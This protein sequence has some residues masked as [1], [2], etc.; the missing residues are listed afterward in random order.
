MASR[1]APDLLSQAMA[2]HQHG[3]LAEAEPLYRRLVAEQP[4][5]ARGHAMLGYLLLQT[6]RDTEALLVLD[7][8]VALDQKLAEAHAWRG[9]VLQRAGRLD[10]AVV[11]YTA[12]VQAD[13]R[14]MGA[15]N[16]LGN[17]LLL[18]RRT[19][20]A[21]PHLQRAIDLGHV[22]PEPHV[23]LGR[24]F[25]RLG[26]TA[27][28]DRVYRIALK[29][30]S[31]FIDAR[32]GLA[33]VL[34]D[35]GDLDGALGEL[36]LAIEAQPRAFGARSNR[37]MKMLYHGALSPETVAEEHRATGKEYMATFASAG[38]PG[39]KVR[40]LDPERRLRIGYMSPDFH[41]HATAFF[42]DPVLSSHD[43]A[44]V[45]V[46]CYNNAE[47]SD[48]MTARLRGLAHGWR[49]IHGRPDREVAALIAADEIDI[50]VDCAGHTN[51]HRLPVLAM[52]P[53]PLQ[54]T[55]LGYPHTTG[56]PSVD[57]RI[58]DDI[59]D[60]PGMTEGLYSEQLLRL[61]EG[62]FCYRAPDSAPPPAPGPLERGEGPVFGCFNNPH[63]IT[64]DVI[65]LWARVVKAVPGARLRLKA[66]TFLEPTTVDRLRRRFADAGLSPERVEIE[67][68]RTF[69][70]GFAEYS[71]I[72]IALDPFPYHGTTSTCE[73]L[74]MAC[75]VVTLPGR[76][77]VSRVGASLLAR[78]GLD[79]LIARDAD[80]YV[81][82]AAGLAAD[83]SRLA[84]LRR[85]LRPTMARS[86]LCDGPRFARHME[87][88]FREIWRRHCEGARDGGRVSA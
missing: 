8:A 66:R 41:L 48:G 54:V 51:N 9:M 70:E 23:L 42:L 10:D 14:H 67:G 68:R 49:D 19:S 3:R 72:D 36:R 64:P 45:H 53:A 2:H 44:A 32:V 17:L 6:K 63:K 39:W 34:H 87:A 15:H 50:L 13:P 58:T 4:A 69:A 27:D 18:L 59:A 25:V 1:A 61:P 79:D 88:A 80:H 73:A 28:A 86:A 43:P 30:D 20:E 81:D 55:W 29:L 21:I 52:K 24:A 71:T 31:K 76:T 85:S 75:P 46:H 78:V 26:R 5:G 11:A 57:Y 74:W 60:P 62:T 83:P 47:Q 37:V 82:I 7:R 35:A 40:D 33:N 77:C 84:E 22:R 16:N 65:T 38:D 12:A 56:L